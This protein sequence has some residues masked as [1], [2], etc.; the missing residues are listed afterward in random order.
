[1]KARRNPFVKAACVSAFLMLAC[2]AQAQDKIKVGFMLP[3]HRHL[4]GARHRDRERLPALRAGAGRQARRPRARVLQGRRRIRAVEGRRQHQQADQARQRR[5]R[6][7]H[8]ALGR[9]R[10]RWPRSRRTRTRCSIIP[11]AGADAVT[12]PMCAPNIFRSSF[13]NWQPGYAMGKVAGEKGAKKVVTITWKY[14]AGDESVQ[15]FKDGIAASGGKVVKELTLPFP[16]V[17][18]Q[19]LLTEIAAHEARRRLRVLRRRR[20]RQVRQGL[21]GRGSQQ[22]D[23]A[24]RARA[25]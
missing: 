20:R 5:R 3:V 4:R 21:R 17:E 12:G 11:N 7:R 24:L 1:M 10:W 23:P 9:R 15:G 16:N 25:S 14:A 18:F 8:R 2:S 13:S 19:A 6:R 22:D